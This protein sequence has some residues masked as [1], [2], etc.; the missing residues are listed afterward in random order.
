MLHYITTNDLRDSIYNAVK[1]GQH[2]EDSGEIV[3]TVVENI[4]SDITLEKT[5]PARMGVP[6][7][8]VA[9]YAGG[10]VRKFATLTRSIDGFWVGVDENGHMFSDIT[11][12]LIREFK[13]SS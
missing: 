6:I 10:S 1:A 13:R 8:H 11:S 3:S 7:F 4:L 2:L 12:D 9:A 5:L